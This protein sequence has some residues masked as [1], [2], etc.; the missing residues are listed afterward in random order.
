MLIGGFQN[1]DLEKLQKPSQGKWWG[2][3]CDLYGKYTRQML[4]NNGRTATIYLLENCMDLEEDDVILLPDY[5]CLSV[6]VSIEAPKVKYRFYRVNRDLSIDMEDLKNKL[7]E[8][9]KGIYI[10]HYFGVPYEQSTVD[11]LKN[12]RTERNIPIIEDI[13]QTMLSKDE[14]RMGF[15]DYLVGSTRK[16]LPMTDGGVIAA[17]DGA[18]FRTQ[19]L[20]DAYNEAAYKQLLISLMRDYFSANPDK[21]KRHYLVMEQE[22]N[23]SRY[24]DLSVRSMTEFS[25]NIMFASNLES[26]SERR[27]ENYNYLYSRLNGQKGITIGS[28]PLDAEGKYVPFGMFLLVENRNSFYDYL[29]EKGIIGEIQWVLP[30]D[31]Y[32]PGEDAVYLSEHNLMI[33]CDQR[34]TQKEMCYVADSILSF[35]EA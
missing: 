18:A 12:I 2:L 22:A 29:V 16:W 9:V 13:T 3:P 33:H 31:Y 14:T 28:K 8:H 35:F 5:L 1:I 7:D 21:D 32:T 6:I 10:I 26:I 27:R 15:G 23:K 20:E 24:T 25:R 19:P 11:A 4:T 17:R 34:Y 30:L